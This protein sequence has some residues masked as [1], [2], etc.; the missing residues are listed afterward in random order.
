MSGSVVDLILT[1][2]TNPTDLGPGETFA[3]LGQNCY[4]VIGVRFV[5][6]FTM[7]GTYPHS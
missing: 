5:P 7:I 2:L 6:Y 4:T 3:I 1:I